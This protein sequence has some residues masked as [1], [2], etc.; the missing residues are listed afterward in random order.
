MII[1][2]SPADIKKCQ[3]FANSIDTSFYATRN[4]FNA[5]KRVRDN[6]IGKLGEIAVFNYFKEKNVELTEPDFK[7][8]SRNKKSW[9]YDLKGKDLNLHVKSQSVE[10]GQRYS[11]SFV[12]ENTDK[13]IFK[14]YSEND[15]VCFISVD[16]NKKEAEIRAIT[17]LQDLHDKKLFGKPKLA[18]LTTKAVVYFDTLKDVLKDNILA[19]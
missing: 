19:K 2:F 4:Q 14:E 11:V 1:K 10:Q 12:F 5:D 6:I 15:Y 3:D 9:D 16:L 8:Y 18:Y 17:K 13:H 7:I